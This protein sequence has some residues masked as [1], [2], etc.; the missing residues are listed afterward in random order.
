MKK[1]LLLA[2][3][4]PSL[5]F[6]HGAP[7]IWNGTSAKWLP[8]GLNSAGVCKL[9]ASGVMSSS[10]VSD[11][12]L[13]TS[14]VKAD[15][16][17][18]LTGNWNA[19]AFNITASSFI[20]ALTGNA[21]TATALAAN[22]AA[23]SANQF[24][25]DTAANGDLTCS[26]PDHGNL[27]GLTDDDHTQYALLAGRSGGQTL[28]G[29]TA[30][31]DDLTISS[32]AN[33]T[34]GTI[35]AGIIEVDEANGRV[36]IG[37]AGSAPSYRLH[38]R[39]GADDYAHGIALDHVLGGAN[40][41]WRL[42]PDLNGTI[43]LYNPAQN[44]E[45]W[46][47]SATVQQLRLAAGGADGG[48]VNIRNQ[49]GQ[50]THHTLVLKKLASQTG[51]ALRIYDTDGSTVLGKWT[52]AGALEATGLTISGFTAGVA[53]FN[54]SG[55][56]SSGNVALGSEVSGTLPVAN[57][58]TGATTNTL[59][60]VLIGNG[61]SAISALAPTTAGAILSANGSGAAP[62]YTTAT[63]PHTVTSGSVMVS[64]ATNVWRALTG[65]ADG[66]ILKM[67][68]GAPT[69]STSGRTVNIQSGTSYTLALSDGLSVGTNAELSFTS[70]SAVT[71][72]VPANSTVAFPV[73][74]QID[75]CQDGAGKV[76]FS[77]AGGVTINSKSNNKAIGA[78]YVCVTL[79][80]TATDTW[81]LIG[82]LIAEILDMLGFKWVAA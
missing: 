16:T 45:A 33:A 26:Q 49:T 76:T 27:A 65:T 36:G 9:S 68:G 58:G 81:R 20:G 56:I 74:E 34:K 29:G 61:T 40:S 23:C 7:V 22:P 78:Q 50:T 38:F 30:S 70:G 71:V 46:Q 4:L 52:I 59:N 69:W 12:E 73:G 44:T 62:I 17:R 8:S 3:L 60:G 77:A 10:T 24:V 66:Q 37:M 31:G 80:K 67:S 64:T 51:D 5:A 79:R 28:R 19:G 21:S 39:A 54:G 32:T 15:G 13:A 48:A 41:L 53:K 2:V 72:T 1:F 75:A 14:Y 47:I 35:T 57:G 55:V 6:G 25:T 43:I 63:Y 42:Y 11:S 82:D 18:A